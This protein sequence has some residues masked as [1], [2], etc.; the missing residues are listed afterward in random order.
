VERHGIAPGSKILARV[1]IKGVEPPLLPFDIGEIVWRPWHVRVWEEYRA[2][3]IGATAAMAFLILYVGVFA[4]LLI[5]APRRL[6]GLGGAGALDQMPLPGGWAGFAVGL[7]KGAVGAAAL[8]WFV[9]HRRVRR[10][11]VQAWQN[12]EANLDD[13]GRIARPEFVKTEDVLDA[14]VETHVEQARRALA[15]VELLQARRIYVALPVRVDDR[16][17]GRVIE[18]PEPVNLREPFERKRSVVAIVGEGEAGKSTLACAIARWAMSDDPG[19][20]LRTHRMLPVFVLQDTGNLV[21]AVEETLRGMLPGVDLPADLF[22]ALLSQQR[23]L[24]VVDAITERSEET[25]RH[26]ESL[27]KTACSIHALLITARREPEM[28]AVERTKLF[29]EPLIG[30]RLVP[31]IINYLDRRRQEADSTISLRS[32]W[33]SGCSRW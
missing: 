31:F 7:A 17:A 21:T 23:I 18:T 6:A 24:V 22:G 15:M 30:K 33:G 19:E 20:R 25:Q 13:S 1:V 26:I 5:A 28:G 14:W 3:I 27:Y 16:L 8:P 9:K 11:W 29:P 10:A 12:G 2:G 32:N 4:S